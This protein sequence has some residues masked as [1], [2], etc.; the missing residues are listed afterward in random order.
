MR[1]TQKLKIG[2][3]ITVSMFWIRCSSSVETETVTDIDGNIYKAIKFGNQ[4]WTIENLRT[5]K[6]NDGTQ[7]PLEHGSPDLYMGEKYWGNL[8]APAFCYYENTI[9]GDTIKRYGALYNWYAVAT[10]KLAPK[11]W[12]V[13]T[14][15]EWDTLTVF[16]IANGYNWDGTTDEN[17]IAKSMATKTDWYEMVPLPDRGTIGNEFGKNNRSL[18]SAFPAGLR[19]ESGVF[20][21]VGLSAEWWTATEVDYGDAYYR[22]LNCN[23]E[24]F[25]NSVSGHAKCYGLSVRLVKD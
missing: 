22:L 8:R 11:G 7:I 14:D 15:A 23:S 12:H 9:D 3:A 6:L 10:G 24:S 21:A 25:H 1:I 20:F 2:L 17:R 13:P 18:F 4:V 19:P 5:S 16:L